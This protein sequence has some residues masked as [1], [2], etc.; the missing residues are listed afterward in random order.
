[1]NDVE[2][3][4]EVASMWLNI[5]MKSSTANDVERY[6]TLSYSTPIELNLIMLVGNTKDMLIREFLDVIKVPKST[7]TSTINRLEKREYI[8]RVINPRDKRSFGL[9]LTEKGEQ[10]M[11][12]Y[13]EY[14]SEMGAKIL[15]VLSDDEQ[16]QLLQLLK[17]ISASVITSE[18]YTN[19]RIDYAN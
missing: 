16:Y 19:G 10:F 18:N 2:I 13:I 15:K 3:N 8:E 4:F 17:K 7:L 5:L 12:L 6:Q 1:M 9:I 14:Q 11:N